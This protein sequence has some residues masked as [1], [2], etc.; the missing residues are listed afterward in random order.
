MPFTFNISQDA[1]P[2]KLPLPNA[3]TVI[4]NVHADC[5]VS[6]DGV[7]LEPTFIV[8]TQIYA[9]E[10]AF[11]AGGKPGLEQ[12][13]VVTLDTPIIPLFEAQLNTILSNV[14]GI[15]NVTQTNI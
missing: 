10:D 12:S 8:Y 5:T 1:S 3:Y 13:Y 2:Y 6:I 14:D 15:T 7:A 9:N 11:K 4:T